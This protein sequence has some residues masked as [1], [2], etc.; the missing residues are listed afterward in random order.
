M[1]QVPLSAFDS[2]KQFNL[3]CDNPLRFQPCSTRGQH[4]PSQILLM[5]EYRRWGGSTAMFVVFI[6][7]DKYYAIVELFFN[8]FSSIA[9]SPKIFPSFSRRPTTCTQIGTLLYPFGSYMLRICLFNSFVG[10]GNYIL[11]QSSVSLIS[12]R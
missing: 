11:L 4:L 5:S 6:Y 3:S 10:P 12:A 7:N 8:N 9:A 2:R 1:R